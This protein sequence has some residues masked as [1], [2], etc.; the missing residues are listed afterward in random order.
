M[1]EEIFSS[2][3]YAAEHTAK[4]VPIIAIGILATSFA[5]NLGLMKKL[6]RF[7]E[8]FSKRV[9]INILSALS[10]VTCT[11][12][13][14][15][16]YA[17]LVEGLNRKIISEREVIVTTL[18]S[19]FP[20][21]L[22]HLFTFFIPVVIPILGLFTGTIYVCLIGLAALLKSCIGILLAMCWLKNGKK[23]RA[24]MP[25][26]D[27]NNI[28]AVSKRKALNMS[29]KS[30]YK[31]L[32]R[33]ALIMFVTLFFVSLIFKLNMFDYFSAVL[34]P[35]TNVLGLESE[36]VLICATK[37][38]NSYAG[39]VL[40]GSLLNNG[41]IST[42]G[43]LIALLLGNVVSFSARFFRHSLPLHIS[44]FGPRLGSKTVLV[45]AVA[46]LVIDAILILFLLII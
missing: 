37:I 5:V 24:L 30:T 11:F 6:D 28:K 13:T 2:L 33:I 46:T 4:I 21:V 23:Q 25:L 43:V 1:Q 35:I 41:L 20:S 15:A 44:M 7:V 12:S 10:V 34:E 39:I 45:N 36:V 17:I 16:G 31:L 32:K 27:I 19:S 8:P 22:S 42:K 29:V 26:S 9:K 40:A 14:T 18:I 3:W 38:V